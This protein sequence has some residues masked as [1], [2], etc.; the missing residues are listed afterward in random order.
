M[1]N[2]RPFAVFDIDG[3]IY[4]W[5][6]FHD[7][8]VELIKAGELPI[9]IEKR[10]A[11]PFK[12][13]QHRAHPDAFKEYELAMLYAL[14]DHMS[15]ISAQIFEDTSAKVMRESGNKVYSYTRDL[16]ANLQQQGYFL[17]AISGSFQ[18]VVDL[19]AKK[20]NFDV[21]I[22]VKFARENG[23][24]TTSNY[25]HNQKDKLLQNCVA[26]HNLTWKDSYGVGDTPNDI[27]MLELVENAIAFNPNLALL[28]HA[29]EKSWKIV[30]ERKNV[31]YELIP[32]NGK[33]YLQ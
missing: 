4:R 15:G 14:G 17:I 6:L 28:E 12:K 9:E 19:F 2:Q 24:L 26:S 22:G 18:E 21:A 3:T 25:V 31:A 33:Y 7:I 8:I 13:W 5:Q 32:E 11:D 10:I 16:A 1:S 27:A 29:K 20:Y 23:K 30:V